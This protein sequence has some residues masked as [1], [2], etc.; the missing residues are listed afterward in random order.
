MLVSVDLGTSSVKIAI[1]DFDGN[2]K[3]LNKYP[4]E[5]QDPNEW[6][7]AIEKAMPP[8][9]HQSHGNEKHETYVTVDSTSG[10]FLLID[11][12]GNALIKPSMYYEKDV[13]AYNKIKEKESVKELTQKG[14]IVD[15]SSPLTR[16]YGIKERFH[17][18]Y[19]KARWIVPPATWVLYKLCFKEV[20]KWSD[21]KTD[22]TNALKFG[23]DISQ[24]K[25]Q[26]FTRIYFE[27]GLDLDK[28]PGLAQSG[29]FICEAESN[30]SN[31]L[32]LLKARVHQ[33]MTDGVA[34]ALASGALETGNV[35]VYSGS[36]TVIK[37]V[38]RKL[39]SHPSVYY[40]LHPFGGYLAS[41]TTGFTG[42][43]L[44]WICEKVLGI[45]INLVDDLAGKVRPG[46]EF[47]FIPPGDRAPFYDPS[48]NASL[49][50][51]K[52]SENEPREY[53]IGRFLRGILIG[54]SLSEDYL[55]HLL[56][57]VF[58][59]KATEIGISGGGTKS[60]VH[61]KLRATIYG[62]RI[63]VY[64]DVIN[65]GSLIPLLI[66]ANLYKDVSEVKEKFI[67]PLEVV[68]PNP[69]LTETYTKL[70]EKYGFIWTSMKGIYNEIYKI[71]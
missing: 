70:K 10:S 40:H 16:L 19:A 18:L 6:L 44:S 45:D 9:L 30:W 2:L 52:V 27:L 41:T 3:A 46:D 23:L 25:P 24:E 48:L 5:R 7:Y 58:N 53:T 26:Y 51:L 63:K 62:R 36:T 21:I 71:I 56:E 31:K 14:V 12:Y 33:G 34:S 8:I 42:A 59:E 4:I 54:L 67:K 43:F 29:E 64:S 69:S 65:A 47:L 35:S 32:G 17:S 22:Y 20:E 68:E 50:G 66:N 28:M 57:D 38:T 37:M 61:N 11:E 60:I 13:E 39:V 1:F 49:L 15:A 55:I